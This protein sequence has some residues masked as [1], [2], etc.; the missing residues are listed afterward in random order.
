MNCFG[1]ELNSWIGSKSTAGNF[2]EAN[3]PKTKGFFSCT[4]AHN[5]AR[6]F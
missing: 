6:K 4:L 2:S 1:H 3:L 5:Y